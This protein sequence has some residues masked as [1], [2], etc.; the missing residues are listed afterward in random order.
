MIKIIKIIIIN[1]LIFITLI[2]FIYFLSY[3]IKSL[4]GGPVLYSHPKFKIKNSDI[5][6]YKSDFYRVSQVKNDFYKFY[7]KEYIKENYSGNF[8]KVFCGKEENGF[9]DLIYKTDKFGFRENEDKLFDKVDYIILGDSFVFSVCINKPYDLASQ[10]KIRTNKTILN[11]GVWGSQPYSQLAY[12]KNVTKN[13]KME[14]LIWFFYEGNDYEEPLTE[15]R[16]IYNQIIAMNKEELFKYITTSTVGS[17]TEILNNNDKKFDKYQVKNLNIDKNY[18]QII[19]IKFLEN[20]TGLNSVLKFFK[21]YDSLL[22]YTDYEEIIKNM[23]FFLKEKEIKKKY[24]YYLPSYLRLSYTDYYLN[25]YNN[26]I[27]QLNFLKNQVQ[28][29]AEE[30]GFEFI[31]GTKQFNKKHNVNEIFYYGLPTHFN[32]LGYEIIAEHIYNRILK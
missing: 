7:S 8:I 20:I 10:I 15:N 14:N 23:N 16:N 27:N 28:K 3:N 11:L 5:I 25:N 9:L 31:D 13:T 18:P 6:K 21:K 22:N 19:K 24:I 26:Q 4:L 30:N 32:E 2:I 1:F 12:F 17:Y 29:I